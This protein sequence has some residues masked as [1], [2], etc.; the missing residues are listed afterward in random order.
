MGEA[1]AHLGPH[2]TNIMLS[3][4][5]QTV[6]VVAYVVSVLLSN[7]VRRYIVRYELLLNNC[8]IVLAICIFHTC[9]YCYVLCIHTLGAYHN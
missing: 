3:G 9:S 7:L 2:G 8:V 1:H 5:S 4:L 6:L